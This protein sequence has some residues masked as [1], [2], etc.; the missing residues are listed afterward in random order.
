MKLSHKMRE[1]IRINILPV[2]F[3]AIFFGCAFY[4]CALNITDCDNVQDETIISNPL[5]NCSHSF[6]YCNGSYS[7]YCDDEETC[8]TDFNCTQVLFP[9]TDNTTMSS[10]NDTTID[11]TTT[12]P[13]TDDVRD[14]CKRGVTEMY[15]YPGNCNYY[16]TCFNGY[17][18]V[19]QC[20][21]GFAFN[22]T[23]GV[24]SKQPRDF[25]G[26]T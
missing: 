9:E 22:E 11:P 24:C 13:P 16:Y 2:V 6:I 10:I 5:V 26:C 17:L 15:K 14:R 18:I 23:M 19:Q 12:G 8:N 7:A 25:R 3:A 20:P 4:V 21:M 1:S